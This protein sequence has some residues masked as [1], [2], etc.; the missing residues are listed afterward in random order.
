MVAAARQ[1]K[2]PS[3]RAY[4]AGL[5]LVVIA[6]SFWAWLYWSGGELDSQTMERVATEALRWGLLL[7]F[8]VFSAIAVRGARAIA[9]ERDRRTL[10]FLLVSRMTAAEIVL[11][12]LA[13]AL[14]ITFA[15]MVAGLPVMLLT[16]VVGGVDA[17]LILLAYLGLVSSIPFAGAMA[18]WVSVEVAESR[19]A[20]G[21]FMLCM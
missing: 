13:S 18:V 12:K 10:D 17:G 14:L 20:V 16:H 3:E 4:F 6:G 7:H 11:G 2:L 19:A 8:L 1:G 15:V 9:Q 21:P 5:L